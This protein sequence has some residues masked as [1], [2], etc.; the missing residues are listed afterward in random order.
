MRT[1][2][3]I[4]LAA[5]CAGVLCETLTAVQDRPVQQSIPSIRVDVDLVL[6]NVT[7]TDTRNRF[8][9]VCRRNTFESGKT[10][11]SRIFSI[12]PTRTL[13]SALESYLTRAAAWAQS[14]R[15]L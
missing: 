12:S 6:V 1:V 3:S 9:G 7:V 10:R 15:V 14:L 5:L 13:P 8:V 2:V 4:T 11:S